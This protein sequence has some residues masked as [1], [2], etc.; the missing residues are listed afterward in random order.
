M[1]YVTKES[2]KT[3]QDLIADY[4]RQ[5]EALKK[6]ETAITTALEEIKVHV[7]RL[8]TFDNHVDREKNIKLIKSILKAALNEKL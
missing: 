5:I 2:L 1:S 3:M 6:R 7:E 4:L 8:E